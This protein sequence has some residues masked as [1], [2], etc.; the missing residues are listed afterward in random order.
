MADDAPS[1]LA[2]LF[3]A[4][5]AELLR[6]LAART[7]NAVE[8]EDLAQELWLRAHRAPSGPVANG[9]AYL[10]RVAN[11]L[12]LDQVRE[13][14]RRQKRDHS[15]HAAEYGEPG[16]AGDAPDARADIEGAAFEREEAALLASAIANLPEGARRAFRLHKIDGLSHAEVAAELG[17]SKSGVEKHIALAMRHL[18]AA[19]S[20]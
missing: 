7:G 17:I 2:A 8:A 11:N 1:G 13:R 19:L 20:D 5:R 16:T 3:E 14:V 15:W 12:V 6:F 10:F 4:H 18:R 9:R